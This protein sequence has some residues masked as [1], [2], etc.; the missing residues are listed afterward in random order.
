VI[1][2][3]RIELRRSNALTLAL[4]LIVVAAASAA[5]MYGFWR[6]QWLRFGYVQS[7]G[8]FALVPLALAGGAVLGRRDR[9][10]RAEDL[11]DSTGRPRWQRALP[12]MS[13]LGI[14]VAAAH[15]AVLAA[16]AV[17]IA[18]AGT[19]LGVRGLVAPL[20]DALVLIGAG[21][22]GIAAGRRWTSA[23][24]P[25]VLAAAVLVVQ[26]GASS[27]AGGGDRLGNLALL[28]DWPPDSPWETMSTRLIL[29]RLA[30]AGGLLLA[31]LLL[32]AG[33]SR[34][35]RT[36]AAA[37]LAAG[38]AGL[39]LIPAPGAAGTW[40]LDPAAYRY[41]CAGGTPQVCVTAVHAHLLPGVTA[42]VRR[43]LGALAKLPGAPTRAVELRLDTIGQSDSDQWFRPKPPP[44]TV[45]FQLEVD[46]ATG[47]D[48]DVTESIAMGAGTRWSGC[49][50]GSDEI[51]PAV[52]AAWLL[53]TDTVRLWD[54]WV[55][56]TFWDRY[57][58]EIRAG[59]RALRAL[60]AAEQL[61]RVTALR[62]AA[63]RCEPDLMPI[64]TGGA[65]S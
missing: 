60:P 51:A 43:A 7:T 2:P 58:P 23:L 47:R 35:L 31:G 13:A 4:L 49:G 52:A 62:D 59:V 16:G 57:E 10:T 50:Q 44:G 11:M 3:V 37:S 36:A 15:L 1:R 32:A 33:A 39:L 24:V 65:A 45:Q 12:A 46:P 21:W 26:V 34:L 61:R 30:L 53:D 64:L 18:V 29:S 55:G 22:L 48:P 5:S 28:I 56:Y 19:Y 54:S 17:L 6:G 63:A 38:V 14:A 40:Q 9:R 27:V 25:P 41:V 8:M 42:D 20:V